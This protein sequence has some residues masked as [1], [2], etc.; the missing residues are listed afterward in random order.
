M[1]RPTVT[2]LLLHLDASDTNTLYKDE[3]GTEE[4][5]TEGDPIQF[6]ADKSGNGNHAT[7]RVKTL[8]DD[9]A[10]VWSKDQAATDSVTGA[11]RGKS[12]TTHSAAF[13]YTIPRFLNGIIQSGATMVLVMKLPPYAQFSGTNYKYIRHPLTP[14][15]KN[16]SPTVMD[17]N[18]RM[19]EWFGYDQRK[20]LYVWPPMHQ[21]ADVPVLYVVVAGDSSQNTSTPINGKQ[22]DNSVET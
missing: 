13:K 1:Q 12:S 8:V 21:S 14:L 3:A 6:I 18:G 16:P 7:R 9:G 10:I 22:V 5:A 2:P 11:I 17:G 20:L 19:A 4:V 15:G